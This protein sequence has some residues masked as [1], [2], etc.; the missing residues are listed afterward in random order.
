MT[1]NKVAPFLLSAQ[2]TNI[3]IVP[4]CMHCS[5]QWKCQKP[6]SQMCSNP[7]PAI[8]PVCQYPASPV[9]L[10]QLL[11]S[12][13]VVSYQFGARHCMVPC[14]CSSFSASVGALCLWITARVCQY[15][16]S[17]IHFACTSVPMPAF[18][19]F[20]SVQCA[21]CQCQ[22]LCTPHINLVPSAP[23]QCSPTS[24]LSILHLLR[25]SGILGLVP[26]GT[27][28]RCEVCVKIR[29]GHTV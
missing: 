6:S 24:L 27:I 4:R 26:H 7:E 25:T 2:H 14:H 18:A 28:Y 29:E 21:V 11:C 17:A 16:T 10:Y 8:V 13:L 9:P 12:V 1:C 22:P 15:S 23:L 3:C 20:T 5:V 19:K